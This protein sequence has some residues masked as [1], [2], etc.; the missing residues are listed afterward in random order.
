[1]EVARASVCF[2]A[3]PYRKS[4]RSH[5]PLPPLPPMPAPSKGGYPQLGKVA[6][7]F[8]REHR[9]APQL[10]LDLE[11]ARVVASFRLS[12]GSITGMTIEVRSGPYRAIVFRRETDEDKKGKA[13][14]ISV[15][16]QTGDASFDDGVYVV[17]DES[18]DIVS[19]ML[20]DGDVRVAIAALARRG[21]EVKLGAS[22]VVVS[23]AVDLLV[24]GEP[25]VAPGTDDLVADI[26][27]AATLARVP[28]I[29]GKSPPTSIAPWGA[30]MLTGL[31]AVVGGLALL[32]GLSDWGPRRVV[33][34][35]VGAAVGLAATPLALLLLKR[36]LRGHATSY[37]H[38]RQASALA[39]LGLALCG[40]GGS[41]VVNGAFGG[42][43]REL[44]GRIESIEGQGNGE[45]GKT[46]EAIVAFEDGS[47]DKMTF[48]DPNR[49]IKVGNPVWTISGQGA[50]GV[51][52]DR[53]RL[54]VGN[55]DEVLP[56]GTFPTRSRLTP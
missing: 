1:V 21:Y 22:G 2:D 36:G 8:G 44:R 20:E 40:A 33:L 16:H 12:S 42:P 28:R 7:R 13:R 27:H 6:S 19:E 45:D 43:A 15:E 52:W 54:S 41:V 14:G 51:T 24:G 10:H 30:Y 25:G 48:G 26:E 37:H 32:A 11:G 49:L 35:F 29:P 55:T 46:T 56:P 9:G 50:F 3:V 53:H 31:L 5:L 23:A 18:A 17:T 47:R 39:M 4:Q 38:F 34:P